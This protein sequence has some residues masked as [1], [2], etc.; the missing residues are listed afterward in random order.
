M[1]RL[2]SWGW[3]VISIAYHDD[4]KEVQENAELGALLGAPA[5]SAPFDRLAWWQGLEDDCGIDPLLAVAREA[6]N[7]V[8]L[9]M[10]RG[11]HGLEALG[12]W[13]SFRVRPV[14]SPGADARALLTRLARDLGSRSGRVDL[15]PVPDENG[16]A[17]MLA[18]AFR[19]AGWI[20]TMR[21][22]D[23]NHVLEVGGRSFA[24]YLATRP[25][26]LRTTLKRKAKKVRLELYDHFDAAAWDA[27]EAIYRHSWKPSE[28][29]PDFLRHFAE[30][31]G[32]AG[33]LRMALGHADIDGSGEQPVAAQFWTVEHGTA[34]I[35]KLAHIEAA[36]PISP[37]TALSAAL[38]EQVID[39]DRVEWVDFGTGDNPYKRDWMESERPR[40]HLQ[41]LRLR[42]P[43]QWPQIARQTFRR[44]AGTRGAG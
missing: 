17:Q 10:R 23:T 19:D 3:H 40:Y 24:D 16:E 4:L 39:R 9:P 25:G 13:Y 20:V 41:M 36:K 42:D 26:P 14:A 32:T 37:G 1:V 6:G 44:L 21:A 5:A 31:E 29:N 7:V 30:A 38:F 28:G 22:C 43:R 18:G 15:S 12:N 35:H 34:F 2:H 8:V 33:R 11:G 27:Y